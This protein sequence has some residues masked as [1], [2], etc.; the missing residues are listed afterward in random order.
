MK[1]WASSSAVDTDFTAKLIDVYPPSADFPGGFDLNIGDGI[2]RARFRESLREEKLMRPGEVYPM[3]IKL[4]PT[5]NIF[6]RGHRIRV[7]ISSS[8]FP[9]FD[10]NPEHGRAAQQQP[11]H[12][13]CHE[14]DLSRP[15][16]PV[17]HR[18]AGDSGQVERNSR[19]DHA[20]IRRC[21]CIDL[22]VAG[23]TKSVRRCELRPAATS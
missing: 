22:G 3:T 23:R 13:D 17:A 7:D 16:A 12:G 2:R 14:H 8:N 19:R 10:V 11:P 9:R 18:V 6:K 5:S 21:C 15:R 1:L 4:Y 20:T